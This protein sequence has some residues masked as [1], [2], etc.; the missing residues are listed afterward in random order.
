M[1]F[2]EKRA[3]I[4][5]LF[6]LSEA[7]GVAKRH[8]TVLVGKLHTTACYFRRNWVISSL[9]EALRARYSEKWELENPLVNMEFDSFQLGVELRNVSSAAR[10][11]AIRAFQSLVL[12]SS[13]NFR[14]VST[15]LPTGNRTS[16]IFGA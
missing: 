15:D 5:S 14:E 4:P 13:K 6:H 10:Y 11:P 8:F 7:K 12:Y 9:R 16:P 1:F 2:R 3:H